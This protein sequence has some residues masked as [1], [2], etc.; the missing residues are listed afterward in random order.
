[1]KFFQNQ[2]EADLRPRIQQNFEDDFVIMDVPP[3]QEEMLSDKPALRAHQLESFDRYKD[4]AV[5]PI[6]DSPGTGKSRT[7]IEIAQFKYRK[8]EITA[9]LI[10]APNNVHRQWAFQEIPKWLE[11]PYELRIVDG[12]TKAVPFKTKDRLQIC[13]TNVDTFSTPKKWMDITAWA[14]Y[15]KTF[16]CLDE[17]TTIKSHKAARTQ[18]ILYGFNKTIRNGKHIVSSVPLTKARAVLTGTPIT[19]GTMDAW[20]IM[21]FCSPG[22]WK[23]SY[24]AFQQRYA[25]TVLLAVAGGVT[26]VQVTRDIWQQVHDDKLQLLGDIPYTVSADVRDYIK[27]Q[28]EYQGPFRNME[29]LKGRLHEVAAF[30]TLEECVDMPD[31]TYIERPLS[32]GTDQARAYLEMARKYITEYEGAIAEAKNKLTVMIRLQQIAS[33][34]LSHVEYM[35]LDDIDTYTAMEDEIIDIPYERVATWIKPNIK[36]QAM[37]QD[38]EEH[39]SRFIVCTHFTA[40]AKMIYDALKANKHNVMLYTGWSKTAPIEHFQE[41]KY[42]GIVAN[43][44]CISRGF[45]L[46]NNCHYMHFYSNTF[47]L[48][49]RV[50]VEGRIYRT[51]QVEK[52]VYYDYLMQGTVDVTCLDAL[53]QRRVLLDFILDRSTSVKK[54]IQGEIF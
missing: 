1:M 44:R 36:L 42:D 50:Q 11:I 48:E 39:G 7:I 12:R 27:K 19:N 29:E 4:G 25:L 5:I 3:E 53:K 26:P 45:N 43:T 23:L 46:Q 24:Y 13:C 31:K 32:M 34:F 49:D 41:G 52:C 35:E 15:M 16:V 10:I 2:K 20:C 30:H 9:L 37:M 22:F 51:G 18:H 21:E 38:I 17:C 54:L 6:F 28:D 8:G 33:G 14:N 47:S 40:E